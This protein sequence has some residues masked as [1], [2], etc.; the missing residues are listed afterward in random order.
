MEKVII[1]GGGVGPLAGVELHNK[2]IEYTLT[3]GTDQSHLKVYHLSCP[4]FIPDR[5]EFL[6]G[7]INTNPAQG[8][9]PNPSNCRQGG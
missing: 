4:S 6:L 1:I 2:I 9:A 7:N 5:T 8:N 3:D